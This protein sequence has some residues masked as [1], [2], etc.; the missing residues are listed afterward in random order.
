MQIVTTHKNTDF[1]ALASTICATVLY[2]G[3]FAVLPRSLNPN[4]KAFLSIHKNLFNMLSPNEIDFGKVDRVV[5]V[6][7]DK[8]S[9]LDG[10]DS[11][12][13]GS[14]REIIVWDHHM[15]SG[16]G[17]D[18]I[19][20]DRVFRES[21]GATITL[22]L[23]KIREKQKKLTPMQATLFLTGIYEDTGNLMFPSTKPEDAHAAAWLL[24]HKADLNIVGTF[25]RPAYGEKQ[26]NALYEMLKTSEARMINGYNV[27]INTLPIRGHVP[28][29]SVVL[30]MYREILGVDAAFGIFRG[31]GQCIVIGRSD[32]DE[33]DVG[34]I[35]RTIGGGGHPG[36]G[37]AMIKSVDPETIEK[38]IVEHIEGN[39]ASVQ[40]AD[41][42]SFPVSTVTSDMKM[43]QAAIM[44]RDKGC[45]GFPVLENGKIVGVISRRDFKKI[46]KE[47]TGMKAPVKA[48]MT[49][50]VK[51]IEP[52][53][54]PLHAARQMVKHDIG[55]L[56]V[57]ENG[58]VI[59]IITRSDA[60]T[61]F[62]DLMPGGE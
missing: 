32:I 17:E 7:V 42:M 5:V 11:L 40:I 53:K 3:A 50:N 2:P 35:M 14:G 47:K 20:G 58:D 21:M 31:K 1:D 9:R 25:L 41:I 57:V 23:R 52:G 56:P 34:A 24:E 13:N 6:D 18:R 22:M 27:S 48:F 46:R 30:N 33:L 16:N 12:K 62:Y 44:L 49:R 60:M 59:G 4:V 29:L 10:M 19:A 36:A 38:K 55:R 45:T 51:V 28:N 26:K 61:Y 39:Q 54:S 15:D 8:W 37:S 43:E